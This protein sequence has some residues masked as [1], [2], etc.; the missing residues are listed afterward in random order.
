MSVKILWISFDEYYLAINT[1]H[2]TLVFS[3]QH[4]HHS[5]LLAIKYIF[6]VCVA[7]QRRTALHVDEQVLHWFRRL[8]LVYSNNGTRPTH[9]E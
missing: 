8:K 3:F 4:L 1:L 9:E 5:R 2:S 7:K 6:N